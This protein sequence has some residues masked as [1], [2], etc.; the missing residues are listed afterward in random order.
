MIKLYIVVFIYS[1]I[2]ILLIY[3][4]NEMSTKLMYISNDILHHFVIVI[5]Q[6][7]PIVE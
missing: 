1:I 2:I 7:V 5:Y 6:M 4:L 3:C